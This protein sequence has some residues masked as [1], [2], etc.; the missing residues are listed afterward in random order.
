MLVFL[1]SIKLF[2]FEVLQYC[3]DLGKWHQTKF[4][5][6]LN[7]HLLLDAI[8]LEFL[9]DN[10]SDKFNLV[11]KKLV[12]SLLTAQHEMLALDVKL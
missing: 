10:G 6:V 1:E 9:R 12:V 8:D 4:L 11:L 3:I 5:H 7:N 2:C